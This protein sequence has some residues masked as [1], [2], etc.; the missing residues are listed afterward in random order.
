[1]KT[2]SHP[3]TT[4]VVIASGPCDAHYFEEFVITLKD[5]LEAIPEECRSGAQFNVET[6]F[7][8]SDDLLFS[9]E[10][11][12]HRKSTFDEI[13]LQERLE[14][15]EAE[16]ANSQHTSIEEHNKYLQEYITK[17]GLEGKLIIKGE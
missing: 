13:I 2:Y 14:L 8:Y 17:H 9:V 11:F 5:M 4:K 1:M 3:Y 16:L 7:D 12:Y 10:A 15:E 6:D